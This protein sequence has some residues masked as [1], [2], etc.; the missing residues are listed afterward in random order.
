MPKF[1]V[2]PEQIREGKVFIR[3]KDAAHISFS[4]RMAKGDHVRVCDGLGTE[5]D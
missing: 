4:L 2:E 3:G 5:Y 1:F